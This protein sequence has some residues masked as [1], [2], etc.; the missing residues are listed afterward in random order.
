MDPPFMHAKFL[1]VNVT[2]TLHGT[3]FDVDPMC[4]EANLVSG[5]FS[6]LTV[7]NGNMDSSNKGNSVLPLH[8]NGHSYTKDSVASV[9]FSDSIPLTAL[10]EQ[11]SMSV[12]EISIVPGSLA[13]V[14]VNDSFVDIGFDLSLDLSTAQVSSFL[15]SETILESSTTSGLISDV[16]F[17]IPIQAVPVIDSLVQTISTTMICMGMLHNAFGVV[18]GGGGECD[19]VDLSSLDNDNSGGGDENDNSGDRE[20][21]NDDIRRFYNLLKDAEQELYPG[22]PYNVRLGL[23][24]DG[25][26]PFGTMS[27]S[28]S[29]WPVVL[30]IYN[31]P[32]WMCMKQPNFIMS[33]LIPGP[34]APGKDIDVYLKPLIDELK[35]LWDN[36]LKTFDASTNQNFNM[37]AALLWTIS[38]FSAY[39]NLS[40][41]STK[42][43]FACL[44]CNK[45]THHHRL[46]HWS[47]YC[48]MEHHRF[49]GDN[50]PSAPSRTDIFQQMSLVKVTLGKHSLNTPV[51]KTK[52]S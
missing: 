26:N 19:G 33:L 4:L 43:R 2:S 12:N 32:L 41:W 37:H 30:M 45:K 52:A 11:Q 38:D 48:Y 49:L 31:L 21:P 1:D 16:C 47:K 27:I 18:D 51:N 40:R 8:E 20:I 6:Q 7:V 34:S 3:Q 17:T 42:G 25:F 44:Y 28:Y 5:Q 35:E 23:A 15:R 50:A 13:I 22:Y 36:G 46:K 29:T 39:A 14:P 10:R 24:S 9:I